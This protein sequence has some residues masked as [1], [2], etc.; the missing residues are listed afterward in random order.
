MQDA[1]KRA[2]KS[3]NALVNLAT[4]SLVA[5]TLGDSIDGDQTAREAFGEILTL[6]KGLEDY[7]G[8]CNESLACIDENLNTTLDRIKDIQK[9]MIKQ[10][11]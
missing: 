10:T 5:D 3:L 6:V 9:Q 4:R 8:A 2:R 11:A 7:F 1:E